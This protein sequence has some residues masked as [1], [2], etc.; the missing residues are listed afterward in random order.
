[1]AIK[2][3]I[4]EMYGI[5]VLL[6]GC[7]PFKRQPPNSFAVKTQDY[8]SKVNA[9]SVIVPESHRRTSLMTV[10]TLPVASI[11][12]MF[13]GLVLLLKASKLKLVAVGFGVNINSNDSASELPKA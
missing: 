8:F 11:T 13:I 4:P 6:G 2:Q 3:A 7:L 5:L 10:L 1:M 12:Q 9:S